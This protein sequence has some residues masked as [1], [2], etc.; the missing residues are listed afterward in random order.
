MCRR[1]VLQH[2]RELVRRVVMYF[3]NHKMR[4]VRKERRHLPLHVLPCRQ[5][6]V[7]EIVFVVIECNVK[8]TGIG[9][10][11]GEECEVRYKPEDFGVRMMLTNRPDVRC[12]H[13]RLPAACWDLND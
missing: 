2:A 6:R 5:E 10:Q 8:V 11:L 1:T 12:H 9:T 13:C 4:D 3:V 7:S